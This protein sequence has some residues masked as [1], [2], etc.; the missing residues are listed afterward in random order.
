VRYLGARLPWPNVYFV[1]R[2]FAVRWTAPRWRKATLLS[3]CAIA[4]VVVLAA[5][6]A[7]AVTYVP[8]SGAGSA[9]SANA[10]NQWIA[11]TAQYG[12]R[13]S[14]APTGSLDGRL[15]FLAGTVDFAASD[16]PF[17]SHPMDG[18]APEI[19]A[20]GSYGLVPITAGGVAFAYSLSVPGFGAIKNLRLSAVDVAKIFTGVITN[21]DDPAL[22][23]DNPGL[24]LPNLQIVPVTS[25]VA[26]GTTLAFT[27]WLEAEYPALFA[28]Y[29]TAHGVSSTACSP[30][31]FYPPFVGVSQGGDLGIAGYVNSTNGAIGYVNNMETLFFPQLA[32]A[33]ILNAAGYYTA[34]T[35]TNVALSLLAATVDTTDTDPSL[36]QTE[37]LGGLY[38]NPD[39][40]TY[41]FSYY[42]YLIAPTVAGSFTTAKGTTLSA[43]AAYDLCQGQ[44]D[45]SAL[46]YA[47]LPIN[48]V[49]A[50]I[51]QINRIPGAVALDL[52]TCNNPTFTNGADVLTSTA[53]M[54]PACDQRGPVQCGSSGPPPQLPEG[55]PVAL[56]LS[57]LV[58][59]IGSCLW[60]RNEAAKRKQRSAARPW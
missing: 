28:D 35:A 36:Y 37:Q 47:P 19:P 41:V 49:E 10:V 9:W 55:Q 56:A 30:G 2:H 60:R 52:Q 22:A 14:Y 43:F 39:P 7:G 59:L 38:T 13:V 40:R 24:S 26:A 33:K 3:L 17:Q 21:W 23:A 29:C 5:E 6:P 1:V 45:A 11:E 32:V 48:L 46:G 27:T 25:S 18:S 53:P 54:P 42:G 50:G 31:V 58:L 15:Q 20:S 12:I 51:T 34:P 4:T 8:I 57:G 16:I 44:Q